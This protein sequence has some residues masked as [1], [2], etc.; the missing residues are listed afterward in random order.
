MWEKLK[1][2]KNVKILMDNQI[3]CLGYP[4]PME[5]LENQKMSNNMFWWMLKIIFLMDPFIHREYYLFS[6]NSESS[7]E[8]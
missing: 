4:S 6:Q 5:K 8:Q 3:L 7:L 2:S 1:K